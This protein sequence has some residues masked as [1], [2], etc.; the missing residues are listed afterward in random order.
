MSEWRKFGVMRIIKIHMSKCI[1]FESTRYG[2]VMCSE[3]IK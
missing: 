2:I 1:F 3:N